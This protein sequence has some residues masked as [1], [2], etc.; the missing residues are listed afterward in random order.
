MI[1]SKQRTYVAAEDLTAGDAVMLDNDGKL[2]KMTTAG[3]LR[4]VG[5]AATTATSGT[6]CAVKYGRARLPA[7][8][9]LYPG[10]KL[11]YSAVVAGTVIAQPAS[12][13]GSA[14]I[15]YAEEPVSTTGTTSGTVSVWLN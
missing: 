12:G 15:G 9:T 8:G 1:N 2:A 4:S 14:V 11:E 7:S 3:I 10:Q 13:W 6:N 5:V